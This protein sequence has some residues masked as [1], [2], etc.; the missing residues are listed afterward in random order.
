[1]RSTLPAGA[2]ID[3]M[4]GT[5]QREAVGIPYSIHALADVRADSLAG[6]RLSLLLLGAFSAIAFVL[7]V[8]G[9][10]GLMAFVVGQRK[11]EFAVRQALGS[12][13]RGIAGLV[14][15]SGLAI[16]GIGIAAGIALALVATRAAQTA[17]YG[18]PAGDPVTLGGVS[19]LLLGTLLLA[20]LVP[21]RR[22]SAIAPREALN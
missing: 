4:R 22:A 11:H 3:E 2:L 19:L 15:G 1:V 8:S 12:S 13:R 17:L 7:A 6:R 21:A 9:V 5:L 10:Y 18:V 16:G 14:L 20:C